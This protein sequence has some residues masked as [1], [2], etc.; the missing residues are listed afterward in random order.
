MFTKTL[1]ALSIIMLLVV[2][3]YQPVYT[4]TEQPITTLPKPYPEIK[5]IDDTAYKVLK[6]VDG[7][8]VDLEYGFNKKARFRLLGVDTPETVHPNKPVEPY[9]KEASIFLKNLLGGESVYLRYDGDKPTRDNRGERILS[10]VYRAPDGLSVN[11]ELVRQGYAR[12]TTKY[13]APH[14][15]LLLHYA[16]KA[17][18]ARRGLWN[19]E[20]YLPKEHTVDPAWEH[21]TVYVSQTKPK[22]HTAD[23]DL[24]GNK[25]WVEVTLAEA[26]FDYKPCPECKP[27]Q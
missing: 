23:C 26:E 24:R 19:L 21:I 4:E 13:R 3:T 20:R 7:D 14:K 9:G 15:A 2:I 18:Q 6:I 10:D 16:Y 17:R 5:F 11:F 12:V 1:K 27:P 8:T 22:Y 25:D